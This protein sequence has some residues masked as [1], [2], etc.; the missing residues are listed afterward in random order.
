MLHTWLRSLPE[1]ALTDADD[2]LARLR[3]SP[4]SEVCCLPAAARDR[5]T[6]TAGTGGDLGPGDILDPA[7]WQVW[8]RQLALT[9]GRQDLAVGPPA[10]VLAAA[11]NAGGPPAESA[12]YVCF[13]PEPEAVHLRSLS[14]ATDR[15]L[16]LYQEYSPLPGERDPDGST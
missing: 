12:A 7:L 11:A 10:L 14:R 15:L 16:V 8:R 5:L 2:F 3:R 1:T 9:L 6:A 4:W 13:G